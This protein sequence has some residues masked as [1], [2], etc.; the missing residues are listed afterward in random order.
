[1]KP[2]L[3]VPRGAPGW[4]I[5]QRHQSRLAS[6]YEDQYAMSQSRVPG[7]FDDD[8][9]HD[10]A[11]SISSSHLDIKDREERG[12]LEVAPTGELLVGGKEIFEDDISL[13][14]VADMKESI[15]RADQFLKS[16]TLPSFDVGEGDPA[17]ELNATVL[18]DVDSMKTRMTT[19]ESTLVAIQD[20]NVALKSEVK[21]LSVAVDQLLS[22]NINNIVNRIDKVATTV[23]SNKTSTDALINVL[24]T[25]LSHQIQVIKDMIRPLTS[26]ASL[27]TPTLPTPSVPS[28]IT[29]PASPTVASGSTIPGST[30]PVLMPAPVKKKIPKRL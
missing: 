12:N 6:A 15:E 27:S 9:T 11:A 26:S 2:S 28:S 25:K 1:M 24:S 23:D 4:Y 21:R 29:V 8:D 19:L 17:H 30:A 18:S 3:N 20:E 10:D 7:S 22:L 16:G 13:P 5:R 14:P